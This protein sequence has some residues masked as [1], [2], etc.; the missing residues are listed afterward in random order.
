MTRTH[1]WIAGAALTLVLV[2]GATLAAAAGASKS[3]G[4]SIAAVASGGRE[5]GK[6]KMSVSGPASA[7]VNKIGI[8]AH[9]LDRT[10]DVNGDKPTYHVFLIRQD[11]SEAVDF[12]GMRVGK[13]GNAL[14][15]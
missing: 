15:I 10:P 14:Y 1:G 7:R 3:T 9:K 12:G 11:G 4:G 5:N 8:R 2:A 6:F 13:L